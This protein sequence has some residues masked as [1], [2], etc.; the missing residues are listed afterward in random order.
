M[1]LIPSLEPTELRLVNGPN[2]CAGRVEV[3]HHQQ[4]G[5]VCD[6][7]WDMEDAK[8]VC[9]QLDCGAPIS[10]PGWAKFGRG[11]DPIWLE[12]VTCSGTEAV[13]SE[14]E[15]QTWGVHNCH[16]GEDASVVCSGN[17]LPRSSC[18]SSGCKHSALE[19]ELTF[20]TSHLV[21]PLSDLIFCH[22]ASQTLLVLLSEPPFLLPG[23][24]ALH[25]GSYHNV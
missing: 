25:P 8:V 24:T 11:Y 9:R 22:V 10:A 12:K 21:M 20:P 23:S 16:H 5:T 19:R 7:H 15:A 4:W 1:Y 2:R 13:L 18:L 3:L 6:N 14:C 17:P